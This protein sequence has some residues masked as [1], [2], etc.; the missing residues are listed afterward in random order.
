MELLAPAGNLIKLKYALIYGADAVYAAAKKFGLRAKADNFTFEELAEG[1][2]FAHNLH[3]K[4]Y[5]TVNSYLHNDE[6]D[7][8]PEFLKELEQI[9]VDAVIVSDPGVVAIVKEYTNLTIHLSTQ[10]NTVSWRTVKFWVDNGVKRIILAR[11]LTFKETKEICEK[12]PE[13]EIEIFVHGAMCIAY[14]GRCLLSAFLN[15]RS[16]NSGECTQPCRWKYHLVEETRPEQYF[17]IEE[18]G[19]GTFIMNSKDLNLFQELPAIINS[20]I[21]SIKIEGRMKSAYYVANVVRTYR[22]ALDYLAAGVEIPQ[23]LGEELLKVS[24]RIYGPGFFHGF[25]SDTSQF[26]GSSAYTRDYQY[27]GRIIATED[28]C[29]IIECYSKF[30]KGEEIELIFPNPTDDVRVQVTRM[31]DDDGEEIEFTKP[32][33]NVHLY[34]GNKLTEYGLVRKYIAQE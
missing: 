3:K 8:L 7:E 30:S 16:A 15:N 5:V 32:N 14:S 17:A 6:L 33:T 26:Y 31:T 12:V 18:D 20:G 22:T 24:H 1:V 2:A 11:E 29:A 4:V 10:A 13:A 21:H 25:D 9:G 19:N 27:L 34:T 23:K 28:D